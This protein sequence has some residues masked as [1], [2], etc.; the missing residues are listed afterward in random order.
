MIK[1]DERQKFARDYLP[2]IPPYITIGGRK[3]ALAVWHDP[4]TGIFRMQ[5]AIH[6]KDILFVKRSALGFCAVA[7]EMLAE[8]NKCLPAEYVRILRQRASNQ[9]NEQ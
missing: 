3:Y 2:L 4:A 7:K 1:T 5:Y 8:L 6:Q 9:N